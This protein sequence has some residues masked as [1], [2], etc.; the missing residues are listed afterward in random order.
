MQIIDKKESRQRNNTTKERKQQMSINQGGIKMTLGDLR[1]LIIDLPDETELE[2]Y[3][4][5]K[6]DYLEINE[7]QAT[8]N[9][10]SEEK[11]H[12]LQFVTDSRISDRFKE[13]PKDLTTIMVRNDEES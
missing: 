6:D 8:V 7:I 3:D 11:N 4:S 9:D 2:I 5:H 10:D 12:C 1:T 13:I